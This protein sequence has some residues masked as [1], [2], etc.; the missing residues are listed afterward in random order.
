MPQHRRKQAV[1]GQGGL[2]RGTCQGRL[3]Q[4]GTSYAKLNAKVSGLLVS[5][6]LLALRNDWR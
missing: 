4:T 5:I 3:F 1:L 2:G 6:C